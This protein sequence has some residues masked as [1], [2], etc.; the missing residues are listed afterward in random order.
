[1]DITSLHNNNIVSNKFYPVPRKPVLA[2]WKT[3]TKLMCQYCKLLKS[4]R[5]NNNSRKEDSEKT[6]TWLS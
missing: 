6:F 5:K 3:C 4:N 2:A 1:M